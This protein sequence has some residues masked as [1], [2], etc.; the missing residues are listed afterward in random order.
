[1]AQYIVT[2]N[3]DDLEKAQRRGFDAD[4]HVLPQRLTDQFEAGGLFGFR[5]FK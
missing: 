5:F 2:M 3:S 1:M 4:P